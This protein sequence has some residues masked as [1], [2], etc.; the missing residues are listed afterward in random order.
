M[1]RS[2]SR[3]LRPPTPIRTLPP[4]NPAVDRAELERRV[5]MLELLRG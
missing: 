3:D 4:A 1:R 2:T 5:A